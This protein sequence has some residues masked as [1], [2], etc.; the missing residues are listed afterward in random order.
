MSTA[1]F[2]ALQAV[3]PI[4]LDLGTSGVHTTAAAQG[5]NFDLSAT[6]T[7]GKVGWV[8]DG[9]ALLARDINGDGVINNGTELFGAATVLANGQRAGNGYIAMAALD[10]NHDGKLSALDDKFSELKL[11]VDA[12]HNGVTDSGE[13]KALADMGVLE[14]NLDFSK[15]TSSNNGNL[16]GMVS[17]WTG[18]DGSTHQVAD[19]WF[20]KA[21]ATDTAPHVSELLAG[22][23]AELLPPAAS[24]AATGTPAHTAAEPPPAAATATGTGNDPILAALHP[25]HH[26]RWED[27]QGQVP[28]I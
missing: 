7:A 9:S 23:P 2:A 13:L 8:A 28:L 16:L 21:G 19:V 12:N 14:I 24:T 15:T 5:V 26:K 27:E 22:P 4:V 25:M 10:S 18:N 17:S 3:T 1:Q 20:A 6:G 11:W